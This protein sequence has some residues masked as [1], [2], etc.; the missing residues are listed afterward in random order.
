MKDKSVSKSSNDERDEL[1]ISDILKA[2]FKHE[3]IEFESA[4]FQR[5]QVVDDNILPRP[6][7]T[8]SALFREIRDGR[9]HL[10]ITGAR[11]S[12]S[13]KAPFEIPWICAE[14]VFS[15]GQ[16]SEP[17]FFNDEETYDLADPETTQTLDARLRGAKT[18]VKVAFDWIVM[19][20]KLI[21]TARRLY[22]GS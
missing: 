11:I 5:W 13:G 14:I 22:N 8:I 4:T 10:A 7:D 1:S 12:V 3:G 2:A 18:K 20:M 6:I 17:S 19:I 9:Y 16:W 15:N 21:D